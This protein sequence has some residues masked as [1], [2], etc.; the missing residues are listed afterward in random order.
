MP[1]AAALVDQ[2][3]SE[4]KIIIK[5]LR[6]TEQVANDAGALVV[7]EQAKEGFVP[8]RL[9]QGQGLQKLQQALEKTDQGLRAHFSRE[10]TALLAAFE[11][12]GDSRLVTALNSLLHEHKDLTSRLDQA[13]EDVANLVGGK[14]TS[15]RWQATAGDMRVHLTHTRKLLEAHAE[16]ENE[17]L[18]ELRKRLKG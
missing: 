12:Y 7:L 2:I 3:I 11:Q 13:K 18:V 1:D 14:L 5:E 10:E 17:L 8:G 4:H 9:D 16:I 15:Q 6:A